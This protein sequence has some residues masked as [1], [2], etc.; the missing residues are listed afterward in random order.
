MPTRFSG[1]EQDR[2]QSCRHERRNR[3]ITKAR[4]AI[5]SEILRSGVECLVGTLRVVV[6]HSHFSELVAAKA[7]SDSGRTSMRISAWGK[8]GIVVRGE[9][10]A[11]LLLSLISDACVYTREYDNILYF[12]NIQMCLLHTYVYN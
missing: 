2:P 10:E 11:Y 3:D 6:Y 7:K 4:D 8:C 9:P 1:K 12:V 5:R